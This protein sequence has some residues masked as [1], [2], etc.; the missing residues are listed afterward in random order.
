VQQQTLRDFQQAA[1]NYFA[2]THG[3]PTWRRRSQ[4]Q[5]FCVRDVTVRKLNRR[6][7]EPV[8]P[9][10]GSVRFRLSRPLPD[11]KL[12][13]AR[14]TLDGKGRWHVS[15]PGGRAPAA[16]ARTRAVVGIDRG[17]SNTLATSDGR[18]LRVPVIRVRER[19]RL[20]RLQQR[21]FRQRKGS[22]RHGRSK[23]QIARLHQTVRDRRRNWIEIQTTRLVLDHD[24]VA[25]ENL[26]VKGMVR[27]PRPKP[28]PEAPGAF[29][30]NGAAAKSGLNRSI[31]AQGWSI[32]LA[33]LRDKAQASGVHIAEVDARHTS[34]QCRACGHIAAANRESQ[35]VFCCESCGYQAHADRNAAENILARALTLAPTPGSG[36]SKP[37]RPAARVRRPPQRR[38]N[39]P[40]GLADAA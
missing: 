29:L 39:Q 21:L 15:F 32:W 22:E 9:K 16:R 35:A 18:M 10:A 38:G 7:A 17:V 23:R 4:H 14:V 3:R 26:N 37:K 11:G 30:P 31:H 8:I 2:G 5:G 27:R 6:W 12:G 13:M 28:D 36:A 34:Q 19:R 25:V 24:L 33:R 20:Q 40:R 1:S